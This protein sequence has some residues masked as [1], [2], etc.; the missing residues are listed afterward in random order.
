LAVFRGLEKNR[1]AS[2]GPELVVLVSKA[3]VIP[4]FNEA[5]RL[6]LAQVE[7][8]LNS[9]SDLHLLF[10][11]DGSRDRTKE[12]IEQFI[13][14]SPARGRVQLLSL[15]KNQGKAE[16]VR[17]GLLKV[18]T[19]SHDSVGYIDADFA[20]P[21][22]EVSRLLRIW[23]ER[24]PKALFASRVRLLGSN[25]ERQ[26]KRHIM[27]RVFATLASLVLRLP[28]Y[29]TQCGAKIF[30]VTPKLR[31][32]LARPFSSRWIFDVELIGRLMVGSSAYSVDDFI[33]VP[34]QK[35][36]DIQGSHVKFSD[37]IRAAFELLGIARQLRR[38]R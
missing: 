9:S 18:L 19:Q 34:L 31:E 35:W 17:S 13:A 5:A 36:N 2:S 24:K 4:C 20:T 38:L 12:F 23:S 14:G 8:L 26:L 10:V 37:M 25:I 15:E 27:G 28:V 6:P 3:L 11:N 32:A 22:Y 1:R 16:A 33:E 21:A 29:D 30:E 7:E